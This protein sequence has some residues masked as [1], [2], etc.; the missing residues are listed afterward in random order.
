MPSLF[1]NHKINWKCHLLALFPAVSRL[2]QEATPT[3]P[4]TTIL[5]EMKESWEYKIKESKTPK[6][7]KYTDLTLSL[8]EQSYDVQ[9]GKECPE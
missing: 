3:K 1:S 4:D 9:S 8:N 5:G 2:R 6:C 7:E